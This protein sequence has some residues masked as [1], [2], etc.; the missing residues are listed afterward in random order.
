MLNLLDSEL[1][2]Y[3]SFSCFQECFESKAVGFLTTNSFGN[4]VRQS[5]WDWLLVLMEANRFLEKL[6]N[7]CLQLIRV[8][9]CL[10]FSQITVLELGKSFIL[11]G[12]EF[13]TNHFI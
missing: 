5:K 4:L 10:K 12:F 11:F 9:F 3:F 7:F 13:I 2:L 6:L 8:L 1:L